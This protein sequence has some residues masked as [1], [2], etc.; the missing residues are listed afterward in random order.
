[1]NSAT[2]TLMTG[3]DSGD[4]ETIFGN[5]QQRELSMWLVDDLAREPSRVPSALLFL[6]QH[7]GVATSPKKK[8]FAGRATLMLSITELGVQLGR[9]NEYLRK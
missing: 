3:D 8:L 6:L 7:I 1:M 5:A 4:S 9:A 2:E